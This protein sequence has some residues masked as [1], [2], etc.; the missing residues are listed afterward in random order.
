MIIHDTLQPTITTKERI[1]AENILQHT[2]NILSLYYKP[3]VCIVLLKSDIRLAPSFSLPSTLSSSLSLFID[4]I[5]ILLHL[6]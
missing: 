5:N 4:F 2:L 3:F 6:Y 1:K